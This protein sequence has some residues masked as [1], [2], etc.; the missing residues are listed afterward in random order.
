MGVN[1]PHKKG[2]FEGVAH[3]TEKH[4]ESLL[5]CMQQKESIYLQ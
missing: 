1:I 5:Q 3:P 2:N 4:W